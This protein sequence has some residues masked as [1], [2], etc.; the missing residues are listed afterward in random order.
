MLHGKW[1]VIATSSGQGSSSASRDMLPCPAGSE[2]LT[3]IDEKLTGTFS[4]GSVE[5]LAI[6]GAPR[7]G[8]RLWFLWSMFPPKYEPASQRFEAPE[9]VFRDGKV[10]EFSSSAR[11]RVR[12]LLL[13]SATRLD[14]NDRPE[15]HW[16]RR[17]P[18]ACARMQNTP[19]TAR[20]PA[21]LGGGWD[22][23]QLHE[24]RDPNPQP[25]LDACCEPQ[26]SCR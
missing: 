13:W 4:S 26:P 19:A 25:K 6:L 22:S 12:A 1:K 7:R 3:G 14:W 8:R 16:Q 15:L 23:R 21:A 10:F 18:A 2:E 9:V 11:A 20:Q 24:R 5:P 17:W